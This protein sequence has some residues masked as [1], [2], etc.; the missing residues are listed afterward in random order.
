MASEATSESNTAASNAAG[1]TGVRYQYADDT[2]RVS[3][4]DKDTGSDERLEVTGVDRSDAWFTNQKRTYDLHQSLDT[5]DILD[6][7]RLRGKLDSGEILHQGKLNSMEL[8][9][10][11]Q[12]MRHTEAEFNQ[13]MRHADTMQA[14]TAGVVGEMV[15]AIAN[16]TADYVVERMPKK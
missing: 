10:R 2:S 11:E 8:A 16:K 12:R 9:E 1:A 15:E 13:R 14:M 6:R 5:E 3:D 4:F 7:R